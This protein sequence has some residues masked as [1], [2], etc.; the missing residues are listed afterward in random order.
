MATYSDL[1]KQNVAP[2]TA[3]KIGV[4]DSNG[5]RVGEISLGDFKPDYGERL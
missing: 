5:E 3:K 1:I 4:Y 2:Y